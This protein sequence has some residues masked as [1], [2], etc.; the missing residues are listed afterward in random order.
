VLVILAPVG[1][2]L[3]LQGLNVAI[4]Q[5]VAHTAALLR[6]TIVQ[7]VATVAAF[8]VGLLG[9][10]RG[11][12]VA[13][14]VVSLIFEPLYLAM[15]ARSIELPLREW[16]RAVS[17]SLQAGVGMLAVVLGARVALVAA[18]ASPTV[19]L[20]AC[21]LLGAIV[22]LPLARWREPAVVDELR[23]MRARMRP[24]EPVRAPT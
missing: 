17:G 21:V 7:S 15:T 20:V 6:F 22:Y 8:A 14:L 3:A 16:L 12:A 5:A 2:M 13:F 19:R 11:V 24:A 9:G 23:A 10:I 1:L 18:G 4:I